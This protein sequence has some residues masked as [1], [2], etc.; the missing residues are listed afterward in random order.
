VAALAEIIA[1]PSTHT[2]LTIGVF[3]TW[4]SGKTS[5]MRMVRKQLPKGSRV[6]WFDAWK[7]AHEATLWRAL[8][9]QVLATLQT[10]LPKGD[11]DENQKA[12]TELDDLQTT[13]YNSVDREEVGRVTVD[14][15][16]MVKGSVL[17][18]THLT[19]SLLPGL[20]PALS[21]ML[22]KAQQQISGDDLSM[23]F[24]AIDR[25][26]S[27][28]H[29][30]QIQ[31]LEQFQDRFRDLVKQHVV[32]KGRRLIVFVDDLDRCLPE[33]AVEVLEAIKLFL[34][35]PGCVFVLG[36][37][38]DVIARGI[39]IKY[40]ELGL[41]GEKS[42][43]GRGR[44]VID[45]ARYLEKIIQLPFQ[46]PP[47]ERSQMTSFVEG[48]VGEW[49]HSECPTVFAEGLGDNPRQVKRT[50]NVFLL[51]WQLAQKRKVGLPLRLAK[52]V[53]IQHIYPELYEVLKTTPRLLRELED[54]YRAT[55]AMPPD[56]EGRGDGE[57]VEPPP[58]LEPF[59]NRAPVR[60]LL[61]IHPV[62]MQ[63]ANFSGLS[64]DE[65]G[66]YFTLTRRAEAPQ[67]GPVE[68]SRVLF[69]PQSVRVPAGP[70]LMGS[71]RE[72]VERLIAQGV[73]E[74]YAQAES[75]QHRLELS[76]YFIGKYPVTNTEYQAFVRDAGHDPPRG[77]DGQD[78]PEGK[79]DHPVVNIT[80][81]DAV[82]YC[83]WLSQNTGK[84]YRLPSEAEW[85][86]AARGTDGQIY[87]WGDEWEASRLNSAEGETR[88]T[89]P[90]GQYSPD[91]DS[92]YGCADMAGNVWEW[93]LSLWGREFERPDYRYPYSPGDGRE[94]PG[95]EG[96]RVLRGGSF[97]SGRR[98]ARCAYRGG[99]Y[100]GS[101]DSHGGFR[102][103]LAPGL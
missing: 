29:I 102:V 2:P 9:L 63:E 81:F 90:V 71:T 19:I 62:D 16:K 93:T 55:S 32:A 25:E 75:P 94:D 73:D 3:G 28:I 61:T 103:V 72:Q 12:L 47:I 37:D 23:I 50:V 13:L 80:W 79:G 5:L 98:G 59:I 44:F 74:D 26:R 40:R 60:R 76:E 10:A 34:D 97:S 49:P 65:L 64:S 53:A 41:L 14:W 82:A 51:L 36:L 66:L 39:E 18:M 22:E 89:T 92:P 67:V 15:S 38:Q 87:P 4:G 88:D 68:A 33:K 83:E 57:R 99:F 6:T 42:G 101:G 69:E 100:P 17:G 1:S 78:F 77:W 70:F 30:E 35:V 91:G 96:L 7:Y 20:G 95:T 54:Y 43:D 56:V 85:E 45:G 27:Q 48:L 24:D 84:N 11:S 31:F 21:K 8:L 46:I 52:V 86:K 58:V